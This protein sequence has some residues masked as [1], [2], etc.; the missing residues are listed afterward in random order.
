MKTTRL[1]LLIAYDGR[2]FRGWQSQATSDAVQDHIERAFEKL[3]GARVVVHGSGRT[4]AG[5]HALGQVAHADVPRGKFDLRTW[6]SALNANLPPQ[7]RVLRV[8]RAPAD[9]HARFSARGKIYEYRLWS[10]PALHP[11]EIGRAWHVPTP[12]DLDLMRAGAKLLEGTHDFAGFAANRGK[13]EK[14]TVRT[15]R[16]I[17]II[18]RGPLVTLRFEGN[19]FLYRMVR[20]LTGSLVRVAQGKA[21]PDWLRGLLDG[22]GATKSN[23]A[24][25]P[26]GLFLVRVLY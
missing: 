15:I 18:R 23:F 14:D 5:V 6:L 22:K 16:A 12:L 24:A 13:V 11:L 21:S 26:D 25:P 9:Y 1:K 7:V 20:L 3:C 17:R 10:G 4:D 8:N 2:G 19:G